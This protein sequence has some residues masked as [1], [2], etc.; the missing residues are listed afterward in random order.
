MNL[1][2]SKFDRF[3]DWTGQCNHFRVV[4]SFLDIKNFGLKCMLLS[5]KKMSRLP[6][7]A[8][9]NFLFQWDFRVSKLNKVKDD[10]ILTPLILQNVTSY[11]LQSVNFFS[12]YLTFFLLIERSHWF[13]QNILK[14][15]WSKN[16][17]FQSPWKMYK[18]QT[19]NFLTSQ[20]IHIFKKTTYW[21]LLIFAWS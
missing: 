6:I 13:E 5:S 9:I 7:L 10:K 12:K 15:L 11:F 18:M 1:Q 17:L 16:L 21:I 2:S 19:S 4:F 3:L 8:K 14:K 20:T